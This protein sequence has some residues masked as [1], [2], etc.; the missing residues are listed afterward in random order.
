MGHNKCALW[1]LFIS[2]EA[3][4]IEGEIDLADNFLKMGEYIGGIHPRPYL[5]LMA[6]TLAQ[7]ISIGISILLASLFIRYLKNMWFP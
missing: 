1:T 3:A 5:V 4:I 2:A 7:T 6:N